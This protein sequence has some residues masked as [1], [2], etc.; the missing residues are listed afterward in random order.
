MET[1]RLGELEEEHG[2][3]SLDILQGLRWLIRLRW[4]A[5]VMLLIGGPL[6]W[7]AAGMAVHLPTLTELGGR[8]FPMWPVESLALRWQ[9]FPL[10]ALTTALINLLA[11]VLLGG[12][13]RD[14]AAQPAARRQPRRQADAGAAGPRP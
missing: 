3:A 13:E 11:I 10:F 8:A 1:A 12:S 7:S 4:G 14:G 6:M 9:P 2:R 5:V